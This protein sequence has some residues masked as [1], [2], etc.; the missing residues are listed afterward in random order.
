MDETSQKI[1]D[2]VMVRK[3]E[4]LAEMKTINT[5]GLCWNR[6]ASVKSR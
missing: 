2:A 3:R 1:I 4:D 6:K 5:S